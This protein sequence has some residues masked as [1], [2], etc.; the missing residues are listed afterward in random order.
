[1]F[2]GSEKDKGILERCFSPDE[3]AFLMVND[4]FRDDLGRANCDETLSLLVLKGI[5]LL[6]S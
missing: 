4:Q 5:A 2:K 6:R 3:M 1:M